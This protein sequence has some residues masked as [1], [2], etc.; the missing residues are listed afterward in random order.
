MQ[1]RLT[2]RHKKKYVAKAHE[3]EP[4][5]TS[6]RHTCCFDIQPDNTARHTR[7]EIQWTQLCNAG[8]SLPVFSTLEWLGQLIPRCLKIRCLRFRITLFARH[9]YL[10]NP[11]TA[12]WG[13]HRKCVVTCFSHGVWSSCVF[14]PI[15]GNRDLQEFI[16]LFCVSVLGV[17]VFVCQC[18]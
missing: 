8:V 1:R 10:L 4:T 15:K 18:L 17:C 2:Q 16:L 13:F 3:S 12:T 11:F 6:E 14:F 7:Q 5:V 9:N